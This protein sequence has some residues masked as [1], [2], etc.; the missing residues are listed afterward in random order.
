[1]RRVVVPLD[2]T[3]L[4]AAIL[5]DARRLAGPDGVLILVN[6][7][8]RR[9]PWEAAHLRE[10]RVAVEA[11]REYLTG[12]AARLRAENVKVE[13]ETMLADDTARGIDEAAMI[14]DADMLALAT[15]A[16]DALGRFPPGSIARQA[17]VHSSVPVLIRHVTER[18][19]APVSPE[20]G[21]RRIMVPLD[22]SA[23]AEGALPLVRELA[24]EWNAS[25]WLVHVVSHYP[26][27]GYARTETDPDVVTDD[28]AY[29]AGH[30][31]LDRIALR[32]GGDVHAH[33]LLGSP[34]DE[35][36]TAAGTWAISDVV[37]ST[38][39]RTGVDQLMLGTVADGL[40]HHLDLPIIVVPARATESTN[41]NAP[42]MERKASMTNGE[43]TR[44]AR[45]AA[46]RTDMHTYENP[47]SP[48]I[49][50]MERYLEGHNWRFVGCA[51]APRGI[52]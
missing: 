46:T 8:G 28:L 1:M 29:L 50:G 4:S 39:G 43:K 23:P 38:H 16:R 24:A 34:V 5:S 49:S 44:P 6:E 2:G 35:L 3:A 32:L 11:S 17:L 27:T 9:P 45:N 40:L 52:R 7:V 22:G 42:E 14:L 19:T 13:T 47:P 36:V 51:V 31:Y 10:E 33:V 26:I 48:Q 25:I 15:H 21:E 41:E 18:G 12:V 37:L 20:P 30:R